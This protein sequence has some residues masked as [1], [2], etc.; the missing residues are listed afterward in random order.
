MKTKYLSCV[1]AAAVM[2]FGAGAVQAG[3][4]YLFLRF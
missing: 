2:L 3:T 4:I 1:L